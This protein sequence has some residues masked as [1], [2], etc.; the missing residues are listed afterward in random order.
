MEIY[1]EDNTDS[2]SSMENGSSWSEDEIARS[3][4]VAIG[5]VRD[6]F[7]SWNRVEQM[8]VLEAAKSRTVSVKVRTLIGDAEDVVQLAAKN[9]DVRSGNSR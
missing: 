7:G 9:G 2:D 4:L 5:R 8:N 1:F 6:E 3:V